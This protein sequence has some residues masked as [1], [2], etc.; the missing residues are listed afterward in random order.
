MLATFPPVTFGTFIVYLFVSVC[1][2]TVAISF[3]SFFTTLP[4]FFAFLPTFF[5]TFSC[6]LTPSTFTV[7]S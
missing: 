3:V 5:V 2:T 7:F 1:M 4:V 6:L